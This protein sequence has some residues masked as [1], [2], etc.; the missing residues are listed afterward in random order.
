MVRWGHCLENPSSSSKDFT[1]FRLITLSGFLPANKYS[2]ILT[3]SGRVPK[4]FAD[5]R[6]TSV[7]I[8]LGPCRRWTPLVVIINQCIF[9]MFNSVQN[10]VFPTVENYFSIFKLF[11]IWFLFFAPHCST[12]LR[13][14]RF[15]FFL[16]KPEAVRIM[17]WAPVGRMVNYFACGLHC[18]EFNGVQYSTL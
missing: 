2:E 1:Y 3:L 11:G 15:V 7:N 17:T 14:T 5:F 6:K 12:R 10:S 18:T 9:K 13:L 16:G 4:C 8:A